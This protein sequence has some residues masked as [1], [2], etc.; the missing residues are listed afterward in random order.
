MTTT[1]LPLHASGADL[2][3]LLDIAGEG[4]AAFVDGLATAPAMRA[5]LSP[6]EASSLQAPPGPE[7]GD[8]RALIE[9]CLRAASFGPEAAGP[10]NFAY[11]PNGGLVEAGVGEL[12]ALVLNRYVTLRQYGPGLAAIEDGV[13]RWMTALFGL[14]EGAGGLL[15][16]GGSQAMLAMIVGARERLR[17]GGGSLDAARLYVSDQAHHCIA[18]AAHIAGLPASAVRT[19]P[20]RDGRR[21]DVETVDAAIREDRAAGR[22]P[23]LLVATAGTTNTGA[24]D[25]IAP[26]A[27]VARAHDLWFHVDACYGGFFILTERGRGRLRGIE[28]ADS[29][30]LDPHKS[31]F[32][33]FGTGTLLVRDPR[34]LA[35]AHSADAGHADYL[36]DVD[37]HGKPDYAD[38]GSELTREA[39]SLRLWLPLHLRGLDAFRDAL[40]EKLD[41]AADLHAALAGVPDLTVLEAPELTVVTARVRGEPGRTRALVERINASGEA[42]CASTVLD[43]EDV[44]RLCVLSVRTRRRHVD[45][46]VAA[47]RREL[48]ALDAA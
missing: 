19:L 14:P 35:A 4:L 12:L 20:S 48:A 17:A 18:K 33:P 32:L 15:T 3:A 43:G 1:T 34:R 30:T 23:F 21:L 2:R 36:Q 13:L 40:D 27:D 46:L 44:L 11:I 22:R 45:R 29:I 24:I 41:L 6:D 10:R 25:P 37:D 31:L 7:R 42:L 16:T 38:L 26:L 9:R 28:R 47:V 39:R 8:A 5:P